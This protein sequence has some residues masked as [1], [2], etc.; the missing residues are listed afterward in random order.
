MDCRYV[1]WKDFVSL[2]ESGGHRHKVRFPDLISVDRN[3][4]GMASRIGDWSP[5]VDSFRTIKSIDHLEVNHPLHRVL[6]S[7][8]RKLDIPAHVAN[9]ASLGD[10][11]FP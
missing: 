11:I 6:D 4:P 3:F 5:L 9:M 8:C 1:P 2:F 10:L 7:I